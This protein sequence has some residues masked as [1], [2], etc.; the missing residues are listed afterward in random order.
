MIKIFDICDIG[1]R[2]K[3]EVENFDNCDIGFR[4]KQVMA[5][6]CFLPLVLYHLLLPYGLSGKLG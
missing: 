3:Q 2:A 6:C 1:F 4:A 5:M